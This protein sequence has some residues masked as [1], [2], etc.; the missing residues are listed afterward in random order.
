MMV[1]KSG[2]LSSDLL[3]SLIIL[4]WATWSGGDPGK[5]KTADLLPTENYWRK[6]S[7]FAPI[8]HNFA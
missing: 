4:A 3:F 1:Q 2:F 5:Q 6:R 8:S 7:R